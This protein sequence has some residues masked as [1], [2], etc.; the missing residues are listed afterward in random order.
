MEEAVSGV[1]GQLAT[2][3]YGDDRRILEDRAD[4]IVSIMRRV[5]GI[6]DLGPFAF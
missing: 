5:P 3:V 4:Q 6:E 1:T 2:K